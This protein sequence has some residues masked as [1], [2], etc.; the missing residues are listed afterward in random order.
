MLLCTAF[1]DSKKRGMQTAHAMGL[2]NPDRGAIT[3]CCHDD[4]AAGKLLSTDSLNAGFGCVSPEPCAFQGLC[5]SQ[6]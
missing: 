3:L 5:M 1:N 4:D 6:T 2:V